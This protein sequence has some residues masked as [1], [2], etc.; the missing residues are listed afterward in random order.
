L[1]VLVAFASLLAIALFLLWVP[2]DVVF[3]ASFPEKPNFR[4]K[5]RWFYGLVRKEIAGKAK[6]R[7]KKKEVKEEKRKPGKKRKIKFADIVQ[8]LRTRGLSSRVKTL[9]K[10][11]FKV[12]HIKSLLADFRVGLDNP[13]DTGLFFAFI[14]PPIFWLS[15]RFPVRLT[16]QPVFEEAAFSGHAQGAVRIHPGTLITPL[17]KF[18]F[19]L[20]ALRLV[21]RLAKSKWKRRKG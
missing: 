12:I 15:S 20:T 6:L 16:V 14:G 7:D 11:L 5:L 21:I 18:I 10:D 8:L 3:D 2:L 4:I 19:S 13:A 1:W 17:L 9:L